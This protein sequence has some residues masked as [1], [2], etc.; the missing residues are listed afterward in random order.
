MA[1]GRYMT[2]TVE[3][4][5]HD[6][7]APDPDTGGDPSVLA[8]GD[9]VDLTVERFVAGGMGLGHVQDGRVVLVEGGLPGDRVVGRVTKAKKRLIT[10]RID[11]LLGAG[12]DRIDPPCPE[13]E[14]GCGGCDLQH[15]RST[16]QTE[17]KIGVVRDALGHIAKLGD[18]DVWPGPALDPFAY[19]TTLRCSVDPGSGRLGFRR[20]RSHETHVVADCMVAHPLAAEVIREAR[21][22][23]ER[24]VTVRVS[25][26][27]GERMVVVSDDSRDHTVPDGVQV[28]STRRG[29]KGAV[30]HE[31]VA[32]RS[33]RI[34]AGSFFQARPD[35]AAALIAAVRRGLRDFDPRRDRLVDLY[36]GVGLFT[37]GLGAIGG[38]LVERSGSATADAALNLA[39]LGTTITTCEVSRWTPTAADAVVADPPRSGLDTG[40]VA[41]VV[42]TG[43]RAV[44]LVS[45][46]PAAMARDLRLLVDAGYEPLGVEL[47][48][49]FPQTHHIETVSSMSRVDR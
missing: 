5:P 34:S 49:M 8:V 35:G 14:A 19:R 23:G 30:L 22:P 15:A 36:G 41:A 6:D 2:R 12:P 9:M 13:V 48:D 33:F 1:S 43:A 26:S 25:V 7:P 29:A 20:R 3:P 45:C 42:A 24:E 11:T 17:L 21:F 10:A 38:E 37:A 47:V 46:D 39:D 28:V 32:G 18:V 44:A 16:S 4:M 31:T 27:T 40:G